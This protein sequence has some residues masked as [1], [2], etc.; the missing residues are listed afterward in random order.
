[1]PTDDDIID[2]GDDDDIIDLGDDDDVIDLGDD[3]GTQS[4]SQSCTRSTWTVLVVDDEPAVHTV[5][6]LG[7]DGFEVEGCALRLLHAY[8]GAE[9]REVLAREPDCALILLD[10]VMESDEEGLSLARWIRDE[11]RNCFVRIVIR[12]GQP[13]QAPESKVV[14]SYDI[15]S[16]LS[17]TDISAQ[18]LRTIVTGGIRSWR[19]LRTIEMQRNALERVIEATG[20][21]FEPDSLQTLLQAILKQVGALLYPRN[22]ALFFLARAPLFRPESA[23]P[24][25]LAASGRFAEHLH[26][27]VSQV[28][29]AERLK[30][31]ETNAS[32][33]MWRGVGDDAVFGF[34][35]G[36]EF[37]PS[38][39]L[40]QATNLSEWD[41][42]TLALFC[43][44]AA[45]AL[46]N[47][48]LFNE[49]EELLQA[50]SRF[51][52]TP[53]ITLL[54]HTDVRS[55]TVGEQVI[56]RLA[57]CFFDVE[58]FTR[59]AE[60]IGSDKIFSLLNRIYAV[61]GPV[62]AAHG[63]V[64]DKYMG[65]GIMVLFPGG[66]NAALDA[67]EAVQRALEVFNEAEDLQADPIVMRSSLEF[68]QV[69]LGTV[70][71]ENRFDTTVIADP[72]N[73][74]SRLQGWCRTLGVNVLS[75]ADCQPEG[76]RQ[77][78]RH[79]GAFPIRGRQQPVDLY[80]HF[81]ASS[82]RDERLATLE[83]F[84]AAVAHR[85]KG[86]WLD[87]IGALRNSLASHAKDPVARWMLSDTATAL[88]EGRTVPAAP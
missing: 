57:V 36:C 8:S 4:M 5:T 59:R 54:N 46:R 2:L 16:Y 31:I 7:L 29:S 25:V 73:V 68:G 3:P 41:R 44:S 28:L 42:Q 22:N 48:R 66:A 69:I 39:Y 53:F 38:L 26:S 23:E 64:I 27:P 37:L 77:Y 55:L 84:E 62:I 40:E 43:S 33:G 17:K 18:K 74:A 50:F 83:W 49:R 12:T 81:G 60:A 6:Q 76:P 13:G 10:V 52:P 75:T 67:A 80:E 56:R 24:V 65:D 1:M 63:G 14:S 71:H 86:D 15:H 51:V 87:A 82:V 20:K 19:D 21:L 32:A 11:L 34:D 79:L 35:L 85:A 61:V 72:V 70:G 45:M 58:G 47:Q 9:A 88:Q 78:R 30:E